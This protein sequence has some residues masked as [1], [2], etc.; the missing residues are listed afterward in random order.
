MSSSSNGLILLP[1]SC[2]RNFQLLRTSGSFGLLNLT[3]NLGA[4]ICLPWSI[5]QDS[6][7][8]SKSAS[9]CRNLRFML[10]LTCDVGAQSCLPLSC[11]SKNRGAWRSF[12]PRTKDQDWAAKCRKSEQGCRVLGL[13]VE[14]SYAR[15]IQEGVAPVFA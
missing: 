10:N 5:T 12:V 15:Y 11:G 13:G 1:A 9:C 4:Q 2:Y 8:C 3:C 14:F 7:N 6:A